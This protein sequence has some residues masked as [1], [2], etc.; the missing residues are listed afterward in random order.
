MSGSPLG[1][2]RIGGALVLSAALLGCML[3]A[4]QSARADELPGLNGAPPEVI[5]ATGQQPQSS[6]APNPA[7]STAP[8]PASSPAAAPPV[9]TNAAPPPSGTGRNGNGRTPNGRQNRRFEHFELSP[10]LFYTISTGSDIV[11]PGRGQSAIGKPAGNTLPLDI[12]RITG[13]GRYRF[14]QRYSLYFQR[15]AHTGASGRT[16]PVKPSKANPLGGTY[17]G[18]SED[19][20]ERFLLADQL[21]PFVQVRAGYAIRTRQCCPAAGAIGNKT[22][23]IHTGFFSDVS[24]RFG[25]PGLGGKPLTTSFRWEEYRH[26]PAAGVSNPPDE[27]VKPTF[28]YTLYSNFIVLHQTKLVP[29]YGIEYFSTYFSYS[30]RMTETY[31]KV[32]GVAYRATR[33]LSYRAYV[34]NDQ[35]G[36]VLASSGDSAHKSSLFMEGTYRLHF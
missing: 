31:R 5:D 35:S 3:A 7:S 24:W 21:D 25:P 36:G 33:D 6:P 1:V 14:N 18:H 10:T 13:D 29:Y 9:N 16:A 17:S 11:P 22:P 19:Y 4:G 30:P 2:Q 15:I 8:S 26:I 28:S 23:R 34:K 27:G 12:W 32:Y 20:E